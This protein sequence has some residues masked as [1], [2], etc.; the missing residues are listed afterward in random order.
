MKYTFF[1]FAILFVFSCEKEEPI[2]EVVSMT[3]EEMLEQLPKN[4]SIIGEEEFTL[5]GSSLVM[6]EEVCLGVGLFSPEGGVFTERSTITVYAFVINYEESD[7]TDVRYYLSGDIQFADDITKF[8]F[9]KLEGDS[10]YNNGDWSIPVVS[11]KG[12]A[13]QRFEIT[14]P[15][16]HTFATLYTRIDFIRANELELGSIDIQYAKN[17]DSSISVAITPN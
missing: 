5:K 4:L 11:G 7:A 2:E 6:N 9:V 12:Y 8:N 15:E 1:L 10:N 13:W 16:V 3:Q 17:N 14:A